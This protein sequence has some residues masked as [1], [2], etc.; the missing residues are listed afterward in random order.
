MHGHVE[1]SED[2]ENS[3]LAHRILVGNC[4][5][6]HPEYTTLSMGCIKGGLSGGE[7]SSS[8]STTTQHRHR[9]LCELIKMKWQLVLLCALSVAAA[10]PQGGQLAQAAQ[11]RVADAEEEMKDRIMEEIQER[12]EDH[13]RETMK[14]HIMEKLG[15]KKE[16][17]VQLFEGCVA[18]NV[19]EELREKF[20]AM[21]EKMEEE[22]VTRE[23][24]EAKVEQ[25]KEDRPVLAAQLQEKKEQLK[26][27]VL[28]CVRRVIAGKFAEKI[29]DMRAMREG[30][31]DTVS[32]CLGEDEPAKCILMRFGEQVKE[33]MAER[34]EQ[35]QEEPQPEEEGRV[36]DQMKEMFKEEVK[37]EL[38]EM[39][40]EK[41]SEQ[42]R[43]LVASCR[44]RQR[45]VVREIKNH[46]TEKL[47]MIR[48][49][50]V[51][52]LGEIRSCAD[53]V[54]CG[55][56][57]GMEG[58]REMEPPME[59]ETRD[60]RM[61]PQEGEDRQ[62]PNKVRMIVGCVF[63][64]VLE[65]VKE[66]FGEKKEEIVGQLGDRL[67]QKAE[68]KFESLPEEA[69]NKLKA[70]IKA[71]QQQEAEDNLSSAAADRSE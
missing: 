6:Q 10:M 4:L 22:G 44:G 28:G 63:R 3:M 70:E 60:R 25:F 21:K 71:K 19:P 64:N 69:Q 49:E 39:M 57:R 13:I 46:I 8:S 32:P 14:E 15:E 5:I 9:R 41:M 26:R 47:D 55:L 52:L 23:E 67:M 1:V 59:P 42:V 30:V 18:E 34:K 53:R 2:F 65:R 37:N 33:K 62:P 7:S 40:Q 24:A 68:D 61:A 27:K 56:E 31:K 35:R 12:L 36:P 11:G 43:E 29:A 51:L 58:D 16:K 50:K 38:M 17:L 45:C 20:M 48:E 66:R 54:A